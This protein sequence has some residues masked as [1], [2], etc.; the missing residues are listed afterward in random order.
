MD[1]DFSGKWHNQHGSEMFLT[2]SDAGRV[3]GSFYTAVGSP[4]PVEEFPLTGFVCGDL[5]SFAV[6]FGK[7]QSLTAWTGQHTVENGVE[8]VETVWHLAV[9]IEDS[10][11]KAWLWSGIRTGA[12]T[13]VRGTGTA[14][15]QRRKVAPSHPLGRLIIM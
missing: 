9:N 4:N 11:E 8:K 3:A 15:A 10:A 5:I 12:D 1:V 2:V 6:N 14:T 13:F 7:Y